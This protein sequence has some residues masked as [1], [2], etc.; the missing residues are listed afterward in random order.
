MALTSCL[1]PV[2][3]FSSEIWGGRSLALNYFKKLEDVMNAAA[4]AVVRGNSDVT[5]TRPPGHASTAVI[6]KE[7]GLERL[8][9]RCIQNAV[10]LAIKGPF[11]KLTLMKLASATEAPVRK[12]HS[13]YGS[14]KET[15]SAISKWFG[16]SIL[17]NTWLDRT[18]LPEHAEWLGT[19][20]GKSIATHGPFDL[21][22]LMILITSQVFTQQET[23]IYKPEDDT[24]SQSE[25]SKL[26]KDESKKVGRAVL[27]YQQRMRQPTQGMKDYERDGYSD[28]AKVFRQ[29]S[30]ALPELAGNLHWILRMRCNAVIL[31]NYAVIVCGA[32][33]TIPATGK[34]CPKS[35]CG[36]C[37]TTTTDSLSHFIFR[38]NP[39]LKDVYPWRQI[40]SKQPLSKARQHT[41]LRASALL[42]AR[43]VI[44][45]DAATGPKRRNLTSNPLAAFDGDDSELVRLLLGGGGLTVTLAG[46]TR[47]LA[48]GLIDLYDWSPVDTPWPRVKRI[49]T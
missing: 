16:I 27:V 22:F 3:V 43:A 48:L 41:K 13:W 18:K 47:V 35:G 36:C 12:Q 2:P 49:W 29:L 28:S 25:L 34:Q 10:R 26:A 21:D 46:S 9:G 40:R 37:R 1:V 33:A 30:L 8:A 4:F 17:R 15:I 38:C 23:N 45:F 5:K 6:L 11:S 7:L 20:A 44:D 32:E 31:W 14:L 24:F 39:K 19:K 42:L